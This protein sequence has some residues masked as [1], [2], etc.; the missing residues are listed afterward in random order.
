MVRILDLLMVAGTAAL[1]IRLFATG[2][3]RR[4]RVFCIYLVF[5][6]LQSGIFISLNQR[7]NAYQKIWVSTEPLE[8]LLY[9][10]VVLEIYALVLQDYRGLSTAGRWT[11]IAAVVV[12]LLASGV[13]FVVPSQLTLQGSLMRY[14]YVAERAVY[15]SLAIFLLSIL[16]FLMQYPITLNRNVIVHSMVFSV[17]FLGNTVIYLLLSM[18]GKASAAQLQNFIFV[19][20]YALDAITLAAICAWLVMLNPAGELRKVSLRPQWM[21]GREEELV[22]QLNHLNAALLRATGNRPK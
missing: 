17:Y 1:S 22:S 9:I 15:F 11:L 3:Y 7:S 4:Y 12:A 10:L 21:P 16:G 8:W 6:T 2:L 13:S 5:A 19:V 20:G 18:R 14:Y